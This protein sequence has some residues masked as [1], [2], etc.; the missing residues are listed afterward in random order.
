MTATGGNATI[1]GAA[2]AG[3]NVSLTASGSGTFR[4][5]VIAGDDVN[6]VASS[7][8]FGG[9]VEA[10]NDVTINAAGGTVNFNGSGAQTVLA[11]NGAIIINGVVT[12]VIGAGGGGGGG[13]GSLVPGVTAGNLILD[14]GT[15]IDV[16]GPI[17]ATGSVIS[18]SVGASSFGGAITAGDDITMS[19]GSLRLNGSLTAGTAIGDNISLTGPIV[20]NAADS[21]WTANR[22]FVNGSID[23]AAAGAQT[24]RL[25]AADRSVLDG[26]IGG[27][28]SLG[29]FRIENGF[30]QLGSVAG[31][32]FT[33]NADRFTLAPASRPSDVGVDL[34][35]S[36]NLVVNAPLF[37]MA[38]G[39][40]ATIL[41][42]FTINSGAGTARLSDVNTTG[43]FE[44]TAGS[45]QL[46]ARDG[47]GAMTSIG[48][49]D[50]SGLDFISLGGFKFS[51]APVLDGAGSVRF[52]SPN[53]TGDLNGTLVDFVMLNIN[54]SELGLNSLVG[55]VGV[56]G[57]DFRSGTSFFDLVADGTS[58]T[59]SATTSAVVAGLDIAEMD[60]TIALS[61]AERERLQ[62]ALGG[63]V[64][65]RWPDPVEARE[66]GSGSVAFRDGGR[67][68]AAA[69]ASRSDAVGVAAREAG[70]RRPLS[71]SA[72]RFEL[73]Q[74]RRFLVASDAIRAASPEAVQAAAQQIVTAYRAG[75]P[76]ADV[77][78]GL[79]TRGAAEEL[80]AVQL[81]AN[82]IRT[83]ESLGLSD[84]ERT[85]AG[86]GGMLWPQSQ[87]G[88]LGG[89]ADFN[90]PASAF[91]GGFWMSLD[92]PIATR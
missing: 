64:E 2:T 38:Q 3:T 4:G 7:V 51:V 21:A 37:T 88:A 68:E 58:S 25:R 19:G 36:G 59:S 1:G 70:W 61:A 32:T 76:L 17:S 5:D 49:I 22:I 90:V 10:A 16:T 81:V 77:V 80:A 46:V 72:Q 29:E 86:A 12:K 71:A 30:T 35:S 65:V 34:G 33:V 9:D 73:V 62:A 89:G 85:R 56:S 87:I 44:V 31:G 42:D 69:L 26:G 50:D 6:V 13:G 28:V 45:I 18:T 15:T 55:G 8:N 91:D 74:V 14:A 39:S 82:F 47:S 66:I 57:A 11:D 84:T 20:L 79:R 40:K 41:G 27:S 24:L 53:A 54:D 43:V 63:A 60:T 67:L 83:G 48:T 78:Q 92:Q 52:A 75:T 23:G